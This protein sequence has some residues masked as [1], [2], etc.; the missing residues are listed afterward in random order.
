MLSETLLIISLLYLSLIGI[1]RGKDLG[2]SGGFRNYF[3][4]LQYAG[5]FL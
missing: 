1:F 2:K 5:G 3:L 4:G